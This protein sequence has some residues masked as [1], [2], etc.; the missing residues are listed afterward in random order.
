[1]NPL[2]AVAARHRARRLLAAAAAN[3]EIVYLLMPYPSRADL[4]DRLADVSA[5]QEQ[6]AGRLR[7]QRAATRRKI[8]QPGPGGSTGSSTG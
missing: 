5:T 8:A 7:T 1:M 6:A 2:R 4:R 3:R